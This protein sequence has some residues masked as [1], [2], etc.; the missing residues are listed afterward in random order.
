MFGVASMLLYAAFDFVNLNPL[1]EEDAELGEE[2]DLLFFRFGFFGMLGRSL[3]GMSVNI[4]DTVWRPMD[5]SKSVENYY[6]R[7]RK[8]KR[9]NCQWC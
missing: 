9:E 5:C 4:S 7:R 8:S 2:V 3:G 1:D 6:R